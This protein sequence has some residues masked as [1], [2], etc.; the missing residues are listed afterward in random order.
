MTTTTIPKWAATDTRADRGLALYRDRS[1]E[2]RRFG[3]GLY[4]VPSCSGEGFYT[5][6]YLEEWCNCPDHSHH[7]E[8][9]CKHILAVSVLTAKLR[10]RRPHE[11]DHPHACM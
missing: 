5:V 11:Q 8:T 4:R 3:T 7:P 10:H 1:H 9:S 6:D 2:I